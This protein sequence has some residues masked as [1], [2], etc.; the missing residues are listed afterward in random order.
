[1]C[2]AVSIQLSRM[3]RKVQADTVPGC[4]CLK[5]D[6]EW[7]IITSLF[8][9]YWIFNDAIPSPVLCNWLQLIWFSDDLYFTVSPFFLLSFPP[10]SF[11]VS[12][13]LPPPFL[14]CL[15]IPSPS[16]PVDS[17]ET[18]RS[19]FCNTEKQQLIS[20]YATHAEESRRRR[21]KRRW[22]SEKESSHRD[23]SNKKTH[24]ICKLL[25]NTTLRFFYQSLTYPLTALVSF[26]SSLLSLW[27]VSF[28]TSL[29][30][31]LID[32]CFPHSIWRISLYLSYPLLL[33]PPSRWFSLY[34]FLAPLHWLATRHIRRRYLKQHVYWYC[35][36]TKAI[37]QLRIGPHLK[38]L[39][40]PTVNPTSP[41]SFF[42]PPSPIFFSPLLD[43]SFSHLP[44]AYT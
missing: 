21:R 17:A 26:S 3:L 40:F 32:S 37:N 4:Y 42:F 10:S 12:S 28:C 41:A 2:S 14:L 6:L 34:S 29:F 25:Y 44:H 39:V 16:R 20:P 15:W 24:T 1:M 18:S 36:K 30:S 27:H 23:K 11:L 38:P 13:Q 8:C 22:R 19:P 9:P 7:P 5:V 35:N 43:P 31:H 33:P